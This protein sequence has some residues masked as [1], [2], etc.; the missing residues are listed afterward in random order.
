MR[1]LT[2]VAAILALMC[3]ISGIWLAPWQTLY[4]AG[5]WVTATGFV[6]GVPTGFVYHVRLYRT[7]EPR[8]ELPRGWYW[9]P[10]R[11]NALLREDERAGVMAWCYLGGVGFVVICVG[12]LLMGSGVSLAL[13]RGV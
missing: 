2:I 1:E 3:L 8:G 12:L 13:V 5:I 4:Q 7:L 10:L 9:R 6:L 11:L